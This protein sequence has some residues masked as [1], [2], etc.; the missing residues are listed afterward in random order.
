MFNTAWYRNMYTN[1]WTDLNMEGQLLMMND[2]LN[3]S[4]SKAEPS[5]IG[6]SHVWTTK[7]SLIQRFAIDDK[8]KDEVHTWLRSQPKTFFEDGIRRLVNRY[9]VSVEKR[10]DYAE[11]RCT[12]YLSQIAVHEVIN[13][14]YFST[15]PLL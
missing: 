6:L 9:I 13:L 8:A 2:G 4:P 5:P 11:K 10:G 3:F 15:L 7:R 14:L 1:G 12:L